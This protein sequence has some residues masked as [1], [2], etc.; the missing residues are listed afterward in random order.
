MRKGPLAYIVVG[1]LLAAVAAVTVLVV[2]DNQISDREA[3]V[4]RLQT[5]TAE[6]EAE[7][8][9]LSAYIQ[10]HQAATQRIET[11]T[12]LANSRFDWE[13]PM[14]QLSLVLPDDVRLTSLTGTVKPGVSVDGAASISLRESIAGPA[15]E[16]EGC[17]AGQEAVARFVSV[18]K[19]IE[20][21]TRVGMQSSE[22]P[23]E[24]AEG[25]GAVAASGGCEQDTLE[26]KFQIV[27]AFDAA[28]IPATGESASAE[29]SA[30]PEAA[31]PEGEASPESEGG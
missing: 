19:E 4:T 3:E 25:S 10:F 15:L 13:S 29:V 20:G 30:A 21:V 18:L 7:T 24:G 23:V 6:T 31:A 14:R 8:A 9:E 22:L 12:N 17:A 27:V 1:A 2:T 11:A 28:P 26:A 16:M 5:E